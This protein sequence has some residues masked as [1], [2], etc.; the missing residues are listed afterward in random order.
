MGM[1]DCDG[2]SVGCIVGARICLGQ[3]HPDH[4][5]DLRLLAVAGAD[6]GFFHK[7]RRVFGNR[8]PGDR[9]HQHGDAARLPELEGCSRVLVHERCLDRGLVRRVLLDHQAQSVM[10]RKEALGEARLVV[11]RKRAAGEEAQAIARNRDDAPAGAA[12]AWIDAENANRPCHP[13]P[14]IAPPARRA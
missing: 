1:G 14:L 10:D 7:I 12:Q 11:G 9:R 3:Q 5:A 13:A 6:D 4:H 8:Q 2:K